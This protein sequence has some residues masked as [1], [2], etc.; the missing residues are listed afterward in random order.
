ML[1]QKIKAIHQW[2]RFHS[3]YEIRFLF[4]DYAATVGIH[5]YR[6]GR[7]AFIDWGMSIEKRI[8]HCIVFLKTECPKDAH[9]LEVS[10]MSQKKEDDD[11]KDQYASFR[12]QQGDDLFHL[13]V[14]TPLSDEE[15]HLL[16]DKFVQFIKDS[17]PP[18]KEE[19]A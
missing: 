15:Q 12:Y 14:G 5:V 10:P 4:L 6:D 9:L 7:Q 17:V 13:F 16:H 3:D 19:Q 8:D 2:N 11:Q 18:K 1:E